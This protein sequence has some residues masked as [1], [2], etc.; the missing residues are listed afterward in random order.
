MN[1]ERYN[2]IIDE[3]WKKYLDE[4]RFTSN[5]EWLEPVPMMDMKTGEEAWGARQYHRNDFINK[6]KTDKEFSERWRLKIEERELS[7]DERF[8]IAYQNLDL[9][10]KFEV[11]SKML[12]FP[13]GHNEVMDDVN[14]PTKLITISYNNETIEVY[15]N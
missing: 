15:E 2:Q 11:E 6:C 5:P 14:I 10:K 1:N 3:S 12:H 4:T 8:R 7:Y 13:H 9:R